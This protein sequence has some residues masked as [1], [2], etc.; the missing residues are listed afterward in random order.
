[1][2]TFRQDIR[3]GL[4]RL[5]KS[6]TFAA[7]AIIS[8]TLGIGANTAIFSL[9]NA[10]L[11]RPLPV[12]RSEELVALHVTN[13]NEKL[14]AFSYP[15]FLDFR[16][17]NEVLSGLFVARFA[18]MSLSRG[19]VNERVWGYLV[20]GNYFDVLGLKMALGR[21]FLPEEDKTRLTHPV[22]ILSY[23]AWQR[24]FG[25]DSQIVGRDILINGH[26]F[27]V[28]GVTPEAFKGTD[29]IYE[30]EIWAP[31]VML[32]WVEP[33]SDWLDSRSTLNIFATGRL[34]PGVSRAQAEASLNLLAEQI[35]R[36]YPDSNEGQQN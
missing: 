26:P 5:S 23:G 9:V 4:R 29:L 12:E 11:L 3:Y 1:M 27:K 13:K 24:R 35:G 33:G 21:G 36:Q 28:V 2:N 34:K 6:P 7:I 25:G 16:D 22:A 20:S 14:L 10:I 32:G 8:L 30:P 17:R 19:G 15:N 31:M 18:P